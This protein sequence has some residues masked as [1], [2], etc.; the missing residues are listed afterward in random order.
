M[1]HVKDFIKL[2]QLICPYIEML[3][4]Y[5]ATE[6]KFKYTE[7]RFVKALHASREI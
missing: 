4:N 2:I 6:K 3:A 1:F 7:C 5:F